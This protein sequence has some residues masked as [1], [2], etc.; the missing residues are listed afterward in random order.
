VKRYVKEDRSR[1]ADI[2]YEKA[3]SGRHRIVISLWNIGEALGVLDSCHSRRLL[4][5]EDLHRTLT[6]F[7]SEC[8]KLIRPGSMQ[9]FP[10]AVNTLIETYT[11][12]LRH[13]IYQADA[14][15]AA[16]CKTTSSRLL[17]SA[18]KNLLRVAKAEGTEAFDIERDEE[19]IISRLHQ[20]IRVTVS[21]ASTRCR[22]RFLGQ[23]AAT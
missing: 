12:E 22:T 2:I 4:N 3:Q 1:A 19:Q 17:I 16:T 13:H 5:N 10:F 18:D 11:I 23:E 6:N 21:G 9:I 8:A 15:Q 14:L 7:L 20:C